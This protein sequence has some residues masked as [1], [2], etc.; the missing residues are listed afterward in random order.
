MR[1]LQRLICLLVGALAWH[2]A[3]RA[4]TA[5]DLRAA[6]EIEFP[7]LRLV[8]SGHVDSQL[9]LLGIRFGYVER[10]VRLG[11]TG[12]HFCGGLTMDRAIAAAQPV[13]AALVRLPYVSV[14]KLALRYLILC[15]GAKRFDRSIGGIPVPPL[16]LLMLNVGATTT[17]DDASL[18]ASTLHELYHMV[19][20]RFD[21]FE[22][23]D[24]NQQFAG[25]ANDYAPE[26]MHTGTS[27]N[28][29]FL[30]AYAQ[31]YPYEDRA[32]LFAALML[33]PGDVVARIR[34][35]GDEVLRRKVLFMDQ[36]SAR[37]I[38]LNLAPP[39]L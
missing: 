1:T 25:Y 30:N 32:E 19:E 35:S 10:D 8:A 13:A 14:R 27:G 11:Q 6:Q 36:K 4:Q 5:E 21:A 7:G 24:W 9:S 23:A 38:G 16:N 3:L 33:R 29:G 12:K 17:Y 34:E 18:Q 39:G 28:P 31:T 2:G 15:A 22:D 26:L 37:L 20:L